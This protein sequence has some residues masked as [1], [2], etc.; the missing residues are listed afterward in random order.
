MRCLN[1]DYYPFGMPM[2]NRHIQDA[3]AYRYAYQGQ[4]KD[5]ET[6]KEAFE[7]RLWDG[8][9]GRW[10]TTD[11]AGQYSS[12]YLGMGNNP[13]SLTD[14]DGGSTDDND[15]IGVAKNEDGTYTVM[16]GEL[17]NDLNI[18][19]YENG[20]RTGE[21]LGQMKNKYDFFEYTHTGFGGFVDG[22]I[23]GQPL[24][25][26]SNYAAQYIQNL[27]T[28][29]I[30]NLSNTKGTFSKLAGLATLSKNGGALDVK[31]ELGYYNGYEYSPGV[32]TTGREIGNMLFGENLR[33]IYDAMN[34]THSNYSP[35]N[36]YK[37]IMK[38]AIGKFNKIRN[39]GGYNDFPSYG[40]DLGSGYGI[41][42]GYFN[43]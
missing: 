2:P 10:L 25:D 26:G 27:K 42:H 41:Y 3:N 12:P 39:G 34:H 40:E 37:D 11:P 4:E 36:F 31:T 35:M 33:A 24:P 23:I 1:N 14:P 38:G 21:V 18:Y 9:I 5:P 7:L 19:V 28:E 20:K 17:D 6:G 16:A 15:W 30:Q 8:R 22:A 43:R 29:T 13:I 32:Y